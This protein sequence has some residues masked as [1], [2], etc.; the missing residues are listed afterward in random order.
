MRGAAS[1]RYLVPHF[2]FDIDNSVTGTADKAG[3][4]LPDL[5]AVRKE[6]HRLLPD[7]APDVILEDG[8]R[9]QLTVDVWDAAGEFVYTAT[10]VF[11]ESLLD[12]MR[13]VC[14]R[15]KWD[16]EQVIDAA[17]AAFPDRPHA[18]ALESYLFRYFRSA[19]T[20]AGHKAAGHGEG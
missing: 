16:Q 15:E 18:S 17:E 9:H 19:A 2:Y 14:R 13:E 7:V 8:D 20:E 4:A 10:R 5:E 1:S 3:Q 12:G 11:Y 6:A